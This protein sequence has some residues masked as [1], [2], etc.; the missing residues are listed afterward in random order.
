M[1]AD[2][3]LTTVKTSYGLI[4]VRTGGEG[5]AVLL[6]HGHPRTHMTWSQ[7]ADRLS[8]FLH[9]V[10]PDLPGF[11]RSYVPPD[12]DD[13]RH[14]SKRE[15]A[16]ALIELMQQLGHKNFDVVG[17]DRGSYSAFRMA[18]DNTDLIRKLVV[19]DCLPRGDDTTPVNARRNRG[20]LRKRAQ[21]ARYVELYPL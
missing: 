17:H 7:V 13:S 18:M 8:P 19:I 3:Q 16:A 1:F 10:C 20:R 2:F 12:A 6:L 21:M 11:G 14:S 4:R 15:K 9:V 5:T